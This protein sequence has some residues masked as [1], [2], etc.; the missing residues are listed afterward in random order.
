M[1]A[2]FYIYISLPISHVLNKKMGTQI[3]PDWVCDKSNKGFMVIL[4]LFYIFV[5]QQTHALVILYPRSVL[6]KQLVWFCKINYIKYISFLMGSIVLIS[7]LA[8]IAH[9]SLNGM[10]FK[11]M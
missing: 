10:L 5:L 8:K 9:A 11:T 2:G 6:N 1:L 4:D 3:L 7:S